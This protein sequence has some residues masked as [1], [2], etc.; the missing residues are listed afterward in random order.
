MKIKTSISRRSSVY[1]AQAKFLAQAIR[2]LVNRFHRE[3][4]I[5]NEFSQ[6]DFD[7]L[8][9]FQE[10]DAFIEATIVCGFV[11]SGYKTFF[12]LNLANTQPQ[13]FNDMPF[14]EIRHY[15]HTLQRAEKWGGEYSTS[16]YDAIK[17]GVLSVIATRL[18]SDESLYGS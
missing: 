6:E 11:C 16:L 14:K 5:S 9:Q 2:K 10:Y 18:E 13:V 15:I 8:K 3:I 4:R 7:N 1:E 12:D 17:T